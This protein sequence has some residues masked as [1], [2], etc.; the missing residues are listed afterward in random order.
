MN[1][2]QKYESVVITQFLLHAQ[3]ESIGL[4]HLFIGGDPQSLTP[5]EMREL[6]IDYIKKLEDK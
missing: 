2:K 5:D 6:M 3:N 1:N 4:C